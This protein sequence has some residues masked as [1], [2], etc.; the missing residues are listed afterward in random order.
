MSASS[1]DVILKNF[2]D[3]LCTNF[4]RAGTANQMDFSR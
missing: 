1:P 2:V 3:R 4:K